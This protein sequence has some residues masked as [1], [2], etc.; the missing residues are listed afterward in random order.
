MVTKA[1]KYACDRL[2]EKYKS[3]FFMRDFFIEGHL[4]SD[5]DVSW[6]NVKNPRGVEVIVWGT[7]TAQAC[8]SV[9]GC[10]TDRLYL[11][12]KIAKDA[13]IR[14][15]H[16]SSSVNTANILAAIFMATGQDAGSVA[17][18]SWSHLTSEIDEETKD[19]TMTLSF[20]SLRVGTVGGGTGY[21]NTEGGASADQVCGARYEGP[22][23]KNYCSLCTCPG[24]KH[25]CGYC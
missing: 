18:A 24:C 14:N 22:S 3:K 10:S 17:E 1:T 9:F 6:G 2:H 15:G 12:Q 25:Q 20:P 19:L 23:C 8:K 13:A 4:A 7:I 11:M 21:A 16:F 5:K